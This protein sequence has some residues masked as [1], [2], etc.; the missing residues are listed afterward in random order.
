MVQKS[1]NILDFELCSEYSNIFYGDSLSDDKI[2]CHSNAEDDGGDGPGMSSSNAEEATSNLDIG[3]RFEVLWPM[4]DNQY[5][6]TVSAFD[7]QEIS[8]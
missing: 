4:D 3:D 1:I 7:D 2:T 6:S 8:I 5:T